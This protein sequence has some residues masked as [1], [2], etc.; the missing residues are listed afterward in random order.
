MA[1]A[2][3]DPHPVLG[4]VDRDGRLV[5]AD[6][7]LERLQVDAG[8]ALGAPV[9]LPQL[10]AVVRVAQRLG[11]PVSRRVLAAANDQDV[12]MW[13]RAVPEGED[14]AL[15]IERWSSR[16]AAPPRLADIVRP[17]GEAIAQSQ[18]SWAV[19]DQFRILSVSPQLA[20]A[21]SLDLASAVGQPLT[22]LFRLNEGDEG[23][24]PLLNALGSRTPFARQAVTIRGGTTRLFLSGEPL[25]A[26]DGS[27]AGFEGVATLTDTPVEDE[28]DAVPVDTAIQTALLSPLDNIV[29]SAEAMVDT[30]QQP[31]TDQYGE[32][33]ADIATAARH[34]LSV[35][36]SVGEEAR[37]SGYCQVDLAELACEAAA[38]LETAARAR[39]IAVAIQPVERFAARGDPRSVTQILVNLVSNAVRYS[40]EGTAVTVSFEAAGRWARVH[41]ADEGPGIDPADQ[42]RIFEP[43]QQGGSGWSEGSG[44]GLAISRRLAR[45]MGGDIRLRSTLGQGARFTLELPAASP[46]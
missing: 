36:R 16:P 10:A 12:D 33:A 17:D 15:T 30:D 8:S 44:L 2:P 19:D 20:D 24:M 37:G 28:A 6:P 27:F 3:S 39:N 32:Y 42:E 40:T 29:R 31:Q 25:S 35:I 38:L 7:E 43:F 11:I 45:S 26:S 18:L 23:E 4:R 5:A 46:L 22:R 9:A 34:L 21:L 1:S 14:V 41:V 13:V